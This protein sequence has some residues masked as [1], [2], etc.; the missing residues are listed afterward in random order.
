MLQYL[1]E[2]E[3]KGSRSATKTILENVSRRSVLGGGLALTGFVM[4]VQVLPAGARQPL[5]L[6]PTGA[7]GMPNKTVSDPK[8]FV[9]IDKT[10]TVKIIA[11][12][13]EMG[14]GIRTSLPMVVA[15]EMEADWSRVVIEQSPGDEVKYGNQDTDGSRSMRH[16]IQA[17]RTCGASMRQM[18]ETAAAAKWGVDAK[19]CRAKNHEVHLLDKNNKETGQKLGYGELAEAAMALPV[20]A[21]ETLLY[22]EPSE[23]TLMGKGTVKIADL[24]DITTGKAVYGADVRVPGMKYAMMARP[25]VLGSKVAKFDATAALKVPGVEQVFELEGV[26]TNPRAFGHLGGVVVVANSTYA[27][28]NGKAALVVEWTN[29]P[30]SKYTTS[31]YKKELIA[32][33]SQPGKVIRKQGDPDAAFAK[34]K[35]VFSADYYS[36]HLSQASM[37]PLVAIADVKADK[38]D[39]WAP[40]QSPGGAKNDIA[41]VLGLKPEDVTVHMTLLGGGF[42]RKSKWDYMTEAALVS[43]KIGAPVLLQW[44]REDDMQNGFY[45]TVSNERIEMAIDD[46]GKVIGYRHRSVAPSIISTFKEDD[47]YQFFIEHGMNLVNVPFEVPNISC[48]NGKAMAHTRIGWFRSVSNIPRLFAVQSAVSEVAHMLKKDPKDFLLELIGSDRI[49]DPKANGFPEDFWHYGDPVETFP[50]ST[51]RLKKVIN[52]AADAAG[53]GKKLPEKHG[54]GIA[55]H[56][57]WHT[58]VCTIVH[59]AIDADGTIRV[60]EVWTALDCGFAVNPERVRAQIEGAAVMGM[61]LALQSGI[62]YK[63]GAVEQ[64]NFTDYPVCRMSNFPRKTNV[65]IVDGPPGSR[66]S[67]VGEPGLPPFAPALANAI[68]AASGKRLRSM[69]M[70]DKIA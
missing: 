42:G 3:A 14:T 23:F 46:K 55:A 27:A 22:K 48:E 45:H 36:D 15:D 11:H 65:I 6:Y 68:F 66:P 51:A 57:A 69:P 39:V 5:K 17:M 30:N 28:M 53:W 1:Q 31:E 12:R 18:L 9:S 33:A 49:I 4:A 63:N 8:V 70:G 60:P 24:H 10:G 61:S 7:E 20:P 37:E 59:A 40:I 16:F 2:L 32:T 25:P 29:S 34:A 44:S 47:G 50:M 64:T 54:L 38:A 35:Q 19:T 62:T 56:L 13:A 41:K 21:Q 67:G 43:K 58:Y 26:H 52:V